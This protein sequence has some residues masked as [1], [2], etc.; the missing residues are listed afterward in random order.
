VNGIANVID[1]SQDALTTFLSVKDRV[2]GTDIVS[3]YSE[4][5]DFNNTLNIAYRIV[6]DYRLYLKDPSY[7][8]IQ[9]VS[10]IDETPSSTSTE[11]TPEAPVI[12][13]GETDTS[14]TNTVTDAVSSPAD[15]STS[16]DSSSSIQEYIPS[17]TGIEDYYPSL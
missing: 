15:P 13:T 3:N 8:T 5:E 2:G 6:S 14:T 16:T 10:T 7:T 12:T 4:M 11:V 17:S 9:G 1:A